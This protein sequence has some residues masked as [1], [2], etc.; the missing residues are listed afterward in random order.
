MSR[1]D[2]YKPPTPLFVIYFTKH[3]CFQTYLFSTI[4]PRA[5]AYLEGSRIGIRSCSVNVS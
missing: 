1:D 5:Y 4:A 3:D 2:V